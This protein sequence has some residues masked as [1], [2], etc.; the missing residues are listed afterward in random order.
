LGSNLQNHILEQTGLVVHF[1]KLY[2]DIRAKLEKLKRLDWLKPE[3]LSWES[4][5]RYEQPA[6][7]R[8]KKV[9]NVQ[10]LKGPALAVTQAL[11][12]WRELK[13]R[14]TNQPRNWL[15]KDEILLTL[16][17]QQPHNL[18][19][20]THIRGLDRK[21]RE[22]FG[23]ELIK[24]IDQARTNTPQAL[25]AF[26]KKRK[27]NSTNLSRLQM[28]NAWAHQRA[29][30]L[31]IAPGLLAPAKVLE[32]SVTGDARTALAG[33]REPLLAD[34]FEALLDGRCSIRINATALELIDTP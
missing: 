22:R 10:K 5:E 8:W 18:S 15:M 34:D 31:D 21:V 23:E 4:A 1:Q 20:L 28:L 30:E 9:R 27:L 12:N 7:E 11:A 19:E 3:F 32:N 13:A 24:L 2:L 6:G 14:E 16:A 17:R 25:P 33:W 29:A 26:V